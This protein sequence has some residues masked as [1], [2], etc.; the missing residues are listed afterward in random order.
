MEYT[1]GSRRS[2]EIL[3]LYGENDNTQSG[4]TISTRTAARWL[5]KLGWEYDRDKKGY[6]D[7]HEREDVV[8]YR[9]N[10]FLPKMTAFEPELSEFNESGAISKPT[11]PKFILVTHDESTFSAN[12]DTNYHWKEKGTQPL[13]SKSRGKGLMVSGFLTADD[14]RLRY[15]NPTT[16]EVDQ[17]CQIIP[18][19][20]G[21]NDDGYWTAEKM[22]SQV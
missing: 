19:G 10:V 4:T 12:D 18:Y 17:A 1:T 21:K 7:G 14:G 22:V 5:A 8:A 6:V 9:N 16:K 15:Q 3:G 20:N 2:I 11:N 13:K